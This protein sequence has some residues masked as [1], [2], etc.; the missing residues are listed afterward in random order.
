MIPLKPIASLPTHDVTN[1]PPYIGD[2]DLWHNDVALREG[3]AREGGAWASDRLAAF[4][5]TAGASEIFEKADLA[6]RLSPE[7]KAFDRYGVR[8]N[9]VEFHLAYHDLMATAIENEVPSFAWN[10][11]GA[12]GQVVHAARPICSASPRVA[13]CAPWP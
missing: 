12:G 6:N 5:K 1:M 8:L 13:S 4:G 9:Q 10:H 2:Q 7:I 11:P 3:V